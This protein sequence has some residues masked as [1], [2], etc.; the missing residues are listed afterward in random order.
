MPGNLEI[1]IKPAK[2]NALPKEN[3]VKQ[4]RLNNSKKKEKL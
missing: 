3:T 4:P 1:Q 2:H